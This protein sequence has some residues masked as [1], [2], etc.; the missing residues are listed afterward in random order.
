MELLVFLGVLFGIP[1]SM[2]V[3]AAWLIDWRTLPDP[4][5]LRKRYRYDYNLEP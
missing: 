2:S 5:Q 3:W 4:N 1:F